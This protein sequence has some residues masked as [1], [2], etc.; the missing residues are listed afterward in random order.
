M[1]N[2][3]CMVIVVVALRSPVA[4]EIHDERQRFLI[5]RS[6]LKTLSENHPTL[7][8]IGVIGANRVYHPC[9]A[10]F[11]QSAMDRR[12][13]FMAGGRPHSRTA[14]GLQP[15]RRG[16]GYHGRVWPPM[17]AHRP[18]LAR[19]RRNGA[20]CSL[21]ARLGLS[22]PP[23]TAANEVIVGCSVGK[24]NPEAFRLTL[25]ADDTILGER[26]SRSGSVC[27]LTASRCCS[28]ESHHRLH[29][30]IAPS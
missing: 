6:I 2:V 26:E 30:A 4:Q 1:Q 3:A 28:Q 11:R 17:G 8:I 29:P 7:S 19:R 27:R 21:V 14:V 23:E 13:V 24:P 10:S 15:R 12:R 9:A 22:A 5:Q 18:A 25:A 16:A 20:C